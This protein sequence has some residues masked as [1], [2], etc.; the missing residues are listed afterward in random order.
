MRGWVRGI[1]AVPEQHVDLGAC[2]KHKLLLASI[3]V[4]KVQEIMA[5]TPH[6][7]RAFDNDALAGGAG[8]VCE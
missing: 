5:T 4:V 7:A 2:V 3:F 1:V 8:L 6:R